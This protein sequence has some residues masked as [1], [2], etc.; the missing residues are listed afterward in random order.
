M[1]K[2]VYCGLLCL[3]GAVL[4][5]FSHTNAYRYFDGKRFQERSGRP[6][7]VFILTDDQDA[8]SLEHMPK[9]KKLLLERGTSFSNFFVDDSLCCPSRSSILRGQYVHNHKVLTNSPPLGGFEKFYELRNDESTIAVWLKNSGYRTMFLGKY[10]NGYPHDAPATYVPPGWDEWVSPALGKPYNEFEYQLNE[11]R[12]IVGYGT[13]PKD[14]MVDV[15]SAKAATL[16]GQS[17]K[18]S[19]PFFLYLAPYAPHKPATPAPRHEQL[20]A[21]AKA[22]R[23]PAFDETDVSDKP[24]YIQNQSNLSPET[25]ERIE[26]LYRKRLQ[27]LQSVDDLVEN[28]IHALEQSGR[29]ENTYIFF[30][31]DNGFHMGEHR[32]PPGKG[33]PYDEDIRVPLVVRGPGVVAGR[34]VQQLGLN[35]DL[36]PTFADLAS[37][38]PPSFVDGRSLLPILSNPNPG[39]V[40][41]WRQT[42]LVE[43]WPKFA[44]ARRK[45]KW[46]AKLAR[47][48]ARQTELEA[49][50][51]ETNA[52]S[53][54]IKDEEES[55]NKK[56]RTLERP[57]PRSPMPPEYQALRTL[58][59]L[60]VEY[61]TGERE[62]YDLQ[63][64]PHQLNNIYTQAPPTL[65]HMLAERLHMLRTCEGKKC[66][67]IEDDPLPGF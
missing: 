47:K 15:L 16:I 4:V 35:V 55:A 54:N 44:Q 3:L 33:T 26:R 24:A 2:F 42:A 39:E 41:T 22:P 18:D 17:A 43:F 38:K 34:V 59:Y 50:Q 36:A 21:E 5:A 65:I 19:R 27:S 57:D 62:L 28:V 37:A 61:V 48:E 49:S 31:S 67:S 66:R 52:A 63:T 51:A 6:N 25:L 45:A 10:L 56:N 40:N 20:F 14:F 46:E 29:L 32:L 60:Y 8:A 13:Q 7:I 30:A 1:R 9:V 58:R 64:D 12:Q 11:N 23:T 53:D